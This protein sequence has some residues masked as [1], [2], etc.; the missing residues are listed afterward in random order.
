[1]FAVFNMAD[2]KHEL[3]VVWFNCKNCSRPLLF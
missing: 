1:M 3:E 2:T